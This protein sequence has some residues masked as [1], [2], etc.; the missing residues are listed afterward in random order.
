MFLVF[1]FKN[2][3]HFTDGRRENSFTTDTFKIEGKGDY[4]LDDRL[5][6]R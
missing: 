2:G 3:G 1:F 4:D 6:L 5:E